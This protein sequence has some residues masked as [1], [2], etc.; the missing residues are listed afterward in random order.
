MKSIGI[1]YKN[2]MKEYKRK[3]YL[4]FQRSVD[5]IYVFLNI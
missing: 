5:Y 4:F 2:K 3:G 1:F